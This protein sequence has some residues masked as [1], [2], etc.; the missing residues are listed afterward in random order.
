MVTRQPNFSTQFATRRLQDDLLPALADSE[1]EGSVLDDQGM[2][3]MRLNVIKLFMVVL[4]VTVLYVGFHVR[5]GSR[6][7]LP[8]PGRPDFLGWA[9]A[10]CILIRH[11]EMI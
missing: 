7:W 3:P 8:G 11:L 9:R 10:G 4:V 2:R 5:A 6:S 1:V